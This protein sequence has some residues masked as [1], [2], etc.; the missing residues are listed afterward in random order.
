MPTDSETTSILHCDS[1]HYMTAASLEMSDEPSLSPLFLLAANLGILPS[2]A[3]WESSYFGQ[4]YTFS[5]YQRSIAADFNNV[6]C[7]LSCS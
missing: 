7:K 3:E 2:A 6:K 5:P 1:T 4:S